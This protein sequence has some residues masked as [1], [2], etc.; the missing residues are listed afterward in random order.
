MRNRIRYIYMNKALDTWYTTVVHV[1]LLGMNSWSIY[2]T[3]DAWLHVYSYMYHGSRIYDGRQGSTRWS[4]FGGDLK[5]RQLGTPCR[6]IGSDCMSSNYMLDPRSPSFRCEEFRYFA[7][8]DS[9]G[10][11]VW[12]STNRND[13]ETSSIKQSVARTIVLNRVLFGPSCTV[14]Q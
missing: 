10:T 12:I 7:I 2:E 8:P 11:N 6:F 9:S 3:H 4:L 5:S 14:I 1:W 13:P